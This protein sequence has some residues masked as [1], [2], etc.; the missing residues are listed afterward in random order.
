VKHAKCA[1]K[2]HVL[3]AKISIEDQSF[4]VQL[5][6]KCYSMFSELNFI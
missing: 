2:I 4:V 6:I 3:H 1:L 5:Q